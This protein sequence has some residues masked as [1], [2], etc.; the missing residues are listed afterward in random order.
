MQ[1]YYEIADSN[2]QHTLAYDS[3]GLAH[4]LVLTAC[5]ACLH[6]P[7]ASL[8]SFGQESASSMPPC[9]TDLAKAC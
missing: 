5:R 9:P 6:F 4:D 1:A 7:L 8:H 3:G 2:R